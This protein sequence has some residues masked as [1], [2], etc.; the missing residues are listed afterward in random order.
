MSGLSRTAW[1]VLTG[2]VAAVFL[3]AATAAVAA[4]PPPAAPARDVLA[5]LTP[6][7][8]P[9]TVPATTGAPTTAPSTSPPVTTTV[10]AT[11][12]R[13]AVPVAPVHITH[14]RRPVPTTTHRAP[15]PPPPPPPAPAPAPEPVAAVSGAAIVAYARTFTGVPYLWGGVSR[16][17][18]DCSGLVVVVLH[19][20]GISPPRTADAQMHWARRITRNQARPGDLV[21]G[22]SGGYAHH[23]GIVSGPGHMIDAPNAGETVGEHAFYPDDTMFG[24][25]VG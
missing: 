12:A 9:L 10:R 16:A 5:A 11:R 7:S 20:F 17:G 4:P 8:A 18:L 19:H 14:T 3:I 22:V 23:V 1:A 24:R 21:F 15:P 25:I 6:T 13:H 2:T